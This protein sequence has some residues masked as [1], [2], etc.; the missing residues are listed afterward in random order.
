MFPPTSSEVSIIYLFETTVRAQVEPERAH[1]HVPVL[2]FVQS[3]GPN[4][5]Q[6]VCWQKEEQNIK[7][8]ERM[9][10]NIRIITIVLSIVARRE[11]F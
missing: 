2:Q 11:Y 9:S 10:F 6:L 7:G 1:P 4:S 8:G 3:L 5:V